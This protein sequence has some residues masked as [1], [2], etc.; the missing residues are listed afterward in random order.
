V[1]VTGPPGAA[2]ASAFYVATNGRDTNPGT[3]SAPF[4]TITRARDA[5]RAV[6]GGTVYLRGGSYPVTAPIA[7]DNRDS[8]TTYRAY[9]DENVLVSG[10][11]KITGRWSR[12]GAASTGVHWSV[13]VPTAASWNFREL[14]LNNQRMTRSRWPNDPRAEG[15]LSEAATNPYLTMTAYNDDKSQIT[16]AETVPVADLSGLGAEFVVHA[17]WSEFRNVVTSSTPHVLNFAPKP[18]GMAIGLDS[19]YLRVQDEGVTFNGKKFWPYNSYLENAYAFLDTAKEWYLDKNAGVLHL[20]LPADQ[21]PNS[22]NI[23]A[24]VAEKLIVVQGASNTNQVTR[25]NFSGIEFGFTEWKLPAGGYNEQQATHWAEDG[26][27]ANDN[28]AVFAMSHALQFTNARDV[29]LDRVKVAH[30]GGGGIAF[31][32][33]TDKTK[34]IGSEVFDT[35]GTGVSVGWW[36]DAEKH[37]P[38]VD[39]ADLGDVPTGNVVTQNYIHDVGRMYVGGVGIWVGFTDSTELSHNE[40]ARGN[41]TGIS[42]GWNWM[43]NS[44]SMRNL[45]IDANDI[46]QV[47]RTLT[48]GGGIYVLGN[49]PGARMRGNYLHDIE[50]DHYAKG[51]LANG[52]YFDQGSGGPWS[53]DKNVLTNVPFIPLHFNSGLGVDMSAATWGTNYFDDRFRP[54]PEYGGPSY[55]PGQ[56]FNAAGPPAAVAAL[57]KNAGPDRTRGYLF[58]ADDP[59]V[60]P[61]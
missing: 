60:H 50:M 26:T 23:V 14:W 54:T 36:G 39:W 46:H 2:A 10:G 31:G 25:L 37:S 51:W 6:G 55:L 4:A 28:W 42:A 29:T 58:T 21:N 41:Y 18:G 57:I 47:M 27:L 33:G 11:K 12:Q 17:V 24:P 35:G 38:G 5:V 30:T 13:P 43:P 34:L 44:T 9:R 40:I 32:V 20:I 22:A 16:L 59:L 15:D 49:Q 52:L 3:R 56:T 8:N 19:A 48:D 45:R 7:F 1:V 53:V 61:R